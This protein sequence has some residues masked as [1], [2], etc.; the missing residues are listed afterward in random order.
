MSITFH[1][2]PSAAKQPFCTY[3]MKS[4]CSIFSYRVLRKYLNQ[5]YRFL[6]VLWQIQFR[7]L[8]KKQ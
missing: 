3:Q 6:P 5:D 4:V 2:A 8:C 1:S 7:Y